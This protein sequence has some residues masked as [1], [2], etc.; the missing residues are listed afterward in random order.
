M[1]CF[2]LL[3][4][5]LLSSALAATRI[6]GTN[7][8]YSYSLDPITDVNTS[9]V[10][11]DEQYDQYGDTRLAVRC[12][13]RGEP[14]VWMSLVSK[15]DLM[16][17]DQ[18]ERGLKPAVTVRLGNDPAITLRDRDLTSVVDD[19]DNLKTRNLGLYGPIVDRLVQGLQSGQRLAVRINRPTGGQALTYLFPAAGFGAAW[20]AVRGCGRAVSSSPALPRPASGLAAPKFSQWYFTT[21]RDA[22]SGAV[23]AGLLAGRAHLC[24]LVIETV[25][26]GNSPTSAR[27]SYELDY[28]ENGQAGKLK[29][30]GSDVWQ[31]GDGGN[32]QFRREGQKLIFTLPLNVRVRSNRVYTS[33]NVTG[34]LNF[35][36]VSKNVYE[37]LP[38]RPGN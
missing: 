13:D 26:N 7:T 12:A 9:F 20:N 10:V 25:P 5:L 33:L 36:G 24:D 31:S 27:F 8:V 22:D 19:R 29:L 4:P 34:T 21:C 2:L 16:T 35:G 1:K 30:D 15:N 6:P 23:R 11:I 37:P 28:R 14:E 38:V 17:Q 32:V 18:A 3:A